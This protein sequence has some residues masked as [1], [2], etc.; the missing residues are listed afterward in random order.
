MGLVGGIACRSLVACSC[1]RD[2]HNLEPSQPPPDP[3]YEVPDKEIKDNVA[4]GH[5]QVN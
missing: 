3:F 1:N 5:F 4:Y 2:E